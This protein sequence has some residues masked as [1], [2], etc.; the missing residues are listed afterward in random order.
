MSLPDMVGH[1]AELP[2]TVAFEHP[3]ILTSDPSKVT[4]PECVLEVPPRSLGDAFAHPSP[5]GDCYQTQPRLPLKRKDFSRTDKRVVFKNV[6]IFYFERSQGF[7]CVPSQGGSSLGMVRVH[8]AS[9]T[10]SVPEHQCIRRLERYSVLLRKYRA[11][12][13]MLTPQQLRYI[14][15]QIKSSPKTFVDRVFPKSSSSICDSGNTHSTVDT[16]GCA[17]D[18]CPRSPALHTPV[19]SPTVQRDDNEQPD[20]DSHFSDATEEESS[21]TNDELETQL[22]SLVDCYFLQLVPVKKR[23]MILRKAGLRTIDHLERVECQAIRLSREICGCSCSGGVCLP[24]KCYCARNGI[25]CQVDRALFPCSCVESAQCQNPEG[26]I[27]F[28]P[29]RVRTHYLHTRLRL[30]VERA[31]QPATVATLGSNEPTQ[32]QVV[33]LEEPPTKKWMSNSS[34][35]PDVPLSTAT[36]SVVHDDPILSAYNTTVHGAC[37]DCQSD[38]Y[39]HMLMQ[40]IASSSSS[41]H[42]EP[43]DTSYMDHAINADGGILVVPTTEVCTLIDSVPSLTGVTTISQTDAS[44]NQ[45]SDLV[46]YKLND[47]DA[48]TSLPNCA[49][50]DQVSGRTV[51]SEE[52]PVLSA[53]SSCDLLNN[54]DDCRASVLSSDGSSADHLHETE[55]QHM[56]NLRPCPL[57]PISLLFAQCVASDTYWYTQP[58]G[59]LTPRDPFSNPY[60]HLTESVGNVESKFHQQRDFVGTTVA[61]VC[62]TGTPEPSISNTS[63]CSSR[64]GLATTD[65][66]PESSSR[67]ASPYVE[68]VS[69]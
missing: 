23:R 12:K 22:S 47:L 64:G 40:Q 53:E 37:R 3:T 42:G 27:E 65:R 62:S 56:A 15:K 54:L 63:P 48:Q 59:S 51:Q 16:H 24:G 50:S 2:L 29:V 58:D 60:S 43:A 41:D 36:H 34:F 69:A 39:V 17:S 1:I 10:L 13:I 18:F 19:V 4:P 31:Q 14:S 32:D 57:E 6:D 30:D 67:S 9:E 61:N 46:S 33:D 44:A 8:S 5:N 28:D 21:I 66:S 20:E 25:R 55:K 7:V 35:P 52:Q 38:R 26:R 45:L 68:S 11:G 49:P